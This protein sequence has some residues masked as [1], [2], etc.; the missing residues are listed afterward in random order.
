VANCEIGSKSLTGSYG[1]LDCRIALLMWVSESVNN[2]VWPSGGA[3]ATASAARIPLAP[4]RGSTI[5][6]WPQRCCSFS[7]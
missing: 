7:A 6:L 5:T 2:T 3:L 1:S 4:G